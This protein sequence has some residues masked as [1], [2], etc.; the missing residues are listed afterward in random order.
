M[1]QRSNR[2][3]A[4]RTVPAVAGQSSA[5]RRS[6][7]PLR[8][9][10]QRQ[11]PVDPGGATRSRARVAFSQVQVMFRGPPTQGRLTLDNTNPTLAGPA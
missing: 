6:L 10:A 5:E 7:R 2:A 3:V 8:A 11:E 9:I 1:L 4:H